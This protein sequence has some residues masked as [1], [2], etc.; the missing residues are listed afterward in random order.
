MYKEHG[1][2]LSSDL[3]G[4]N[5]N[6]MITPAGYR[7]RIR[8]LA[9]ILSRFGR[10]AV[11]QFS[12]TVARSFS[13]TL[14]NQLYTTSLI[15]SLTNGVAFAASWKVSALN[16]NF[17]GEV[18]MGSLHQAT[19]FPF[20]LTTGAFEVLISPLVIAINLWSPILILE[21][22]ISGSGTSWLPTSSYSLALAWPSPSLPCATSSSRNKFSSSLNRRSDNGHDTSHRR[23][24]YQKD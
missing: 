16:G 2:I 21:N 18:V 20:P 1:G 22:S 9:S 15:Q 11:R 8:M 23:D 17:E 3:V 24:Q 13:H 5:R 14:H 12:T 7:P 10:P 4:K 6:L 19:T